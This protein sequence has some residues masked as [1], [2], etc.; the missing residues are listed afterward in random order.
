MNDFQS[1]PVLHNLSFYHDQ[2][3]KGGPVPCAEAVVECSPRGAFGREHTEDVV[4]FRAV[5]S[6]LI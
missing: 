2:A 1:T 4:Q 3:E 5:T 6:I